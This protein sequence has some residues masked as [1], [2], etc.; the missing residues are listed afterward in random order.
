VGEGEEVGKGVIGECCSP[1]KPQSSAN[2]RVDYSNIRLS[3]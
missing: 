2:E 3:R 1:F